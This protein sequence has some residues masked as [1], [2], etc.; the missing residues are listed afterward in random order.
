MGM[1][2]AG[3]AQ[4][5]RERLGKDA[6]LTARVVLGVLVA[7]NLVAAAALFR[8]WGGSPEQLQQ[9]LSALRG[10]VQ[11]TRVTAQR[12]NT[13]V[14]TVEKTRA[15]A[16]QFLETN[17]LDRRAAY[18]AVLGELTSLA[19]KSGMKARDHSFAAESI[20]GS[21]TLGLMTIT[22]NYEG[23]YADLI[24]LVNA[25]DRSPRFLTIERLQAAPLQAQGSLIV[26]MRLNAFIRG[27]AGPQ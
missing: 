25:I 3:T 12:L 8:P 11:Q 15:E 18:S 2:L 13:L 23:T 27:E 16:D 6:R 1:N 26:S 5:Y 19:E 17:F 9:Q 7:A 4:N 21:D 24:Q 10:Q 22:G 20:E 14:R